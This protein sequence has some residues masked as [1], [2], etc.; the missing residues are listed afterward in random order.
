MTSFNFSKEELDRVFKEMGKELKK[1]LKGKS[2]SYEL[3]VVGGASVLLNYS[4]RMSTIDIDCLDVN[5]ALMNEVVNTIGNKYQLPNGWI[6]TD[7]VKTNSYTP[8]LIQYSSF[9]KSYSN[10]TLI[11]RTIKDEYLVAMKMV[12]ARDYK[13]DYSD[14][15][16]IIN[17]NKS[18]AFAKVE[19]AIVDLYGTTEVVKDE[20]MRFVKSIF[21]DSSIKYEELSKNEDD[22]KITLIEKYKK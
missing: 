12:A 19:K 13:H 3:I 14:I 17:E 8:K 16:G 21:S 15:L 9:Y 11:V 6:N 2:F 22:R 1:K 18:L 4:F 20:M 5:D 10:D 7:F